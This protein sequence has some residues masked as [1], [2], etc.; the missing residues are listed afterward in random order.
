MAWLFGLVGLTLLSLVITGAFLIL[1]PANFFGYLVYSTGWLMV[2]NG[3][4][5]GWGFMLN[6]TYAFAIYPVAFILH[7]IAWGILMRLNMAFGGNPGVNN[8]IYKGITFFWV[9]LFC[10]GLWFASGNFLMWF[11]EKNTSINVSI[12]KTLNEISVTNSGAYFIAT[13]VFTILTYI[14][15]FLTLTGK[16]WPKNKVET[17]V[18]R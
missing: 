9:A 13:S 4:P 14:L 15:L 12:F 7:K 8:I 18:A 17:L 2:A 1:G 11:A 10:I 6:T 3:I 16:L 5:I